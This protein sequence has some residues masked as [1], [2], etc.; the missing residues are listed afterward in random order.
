[1]EKIDYLLDKT[2]IMNAEIGEIKDKLNTAINNIDTN[3]QNISTNEN[4]I[5][6]NANN[7]TTLQEN[8]TIIQGDIATIKSNIELLQ[9]NTY[10]A[11][12]LTNGDFKIN[13]RG[14]PSYTNRLDYTADRWM[15]RQNGITLIPL[16]NGGISVVKDSANVNIWQILEIPLSNLAGKTITISGKCGGTIFTASGTVPS[17]KTS[18]AQKVCQVHAT[19]NWLSFNVSRIT[20]TNYDMYF[21]IA[22]QG[23]FGYEW[24]K[25]EVGSSATKF[26]PKLYVEEL[27][28]CQRYYQ[29]RSANYNFETSYLDRTPQMRIAGT[30]G[31]TTINNVPYKYCDAE[32]Y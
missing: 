26:N 20:D 2:N 15:L 23:N 28:N 9:K 1:M 14:Q 16:E 7:I 32:I 3:A 27:S 17:T 11:N 10:N 24:V 21:E 29:L 22:A 8:E 12:L 13:Q 5:T 25:L 30:T 31:T 18:S 6:G 19:N 4:N